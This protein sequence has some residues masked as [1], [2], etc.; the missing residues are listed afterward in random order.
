MDDDEEED[1]DDDEDVEPSVGNQ[2]PKSLPGKSLHC[3][4]R[5]N[6]CQP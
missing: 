6:C 3:P 2:S 5:P 1:V 4:S